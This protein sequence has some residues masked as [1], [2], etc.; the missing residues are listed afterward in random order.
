MVCDLGDRITK[1]ESNLTNALNGV[2]SN[3]TEVKK[4]MKKSRKKATVKKSEN[5]K[6]DFAIKTNK[7]SRK[8]SGN[9][10][11]NKFEDMTDII[12]E[13]EREQGYDKIND[14]I[15]P[16]SRDRKSYST[17]AVKCVE[18]NKN[19]DVHP[20]FV[21]DNYVCDRCIGRRG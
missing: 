6:H 13:A 16:T 2:I 1:L 5:N 3:N 18:C 20:M 12:F 21:R 15:K 10:R 14:K 9:N 19:F 4:P 11:K 17:K 7:P 8:V